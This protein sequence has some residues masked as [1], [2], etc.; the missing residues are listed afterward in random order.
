MSSALMNP[1]YM[2]AIDHR[3][4]WAKWCDENR[5]DYL[6]IREVKKLAAD[7]FLLARRESRHARESGVL[8]TDLIYG[9]E[10]FARA[11]AAGAT[12]G[13][14]AERAGVFPLEWTG[15][16]AESLPG[17]F[18]KVLVRHKADMPR[19]LVDSQLAKVGELQHWCSTMKKPLVLEVLVSGPE[20]DPAFDRE[21]RPRLLAEYIR[22][23]YARGVVPQ[24]WKIE[25]V[26][27]TAA[28][29][30]I[31]EA[32]CEQT[33]VRQLILGKG[34][35]LE[36]V[37]VWF[38]SARGAASAAGFAIGRTVYWDAAREFLLGRIAGDDA[39]HQMAANYQSVIELW[40]RA[41]VP[42]QSGTVA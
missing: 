29:Q 8:L 24:Y 20:E 38:E 23:A 14:P 9:A 34:A 12:V 33:G 28:M 36:T 31:D 18:A 19:E 15:A 5:I 17:A 2:M 6:R 30:I 35:G 26:P 25:G 41:Q 7:A 42:T 40:C 10:A 13:T 11:T 3:W 16:F 22:N 37:G 1:V 39:V 4:Q 27:D 32:I 21:G